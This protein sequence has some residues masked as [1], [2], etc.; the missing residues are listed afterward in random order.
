MNF[1]SLFGKHSADLKASRWDRGQF[2][3]QCLSCG[4]AMVKPP[5][6]EWQLRKA[7]GL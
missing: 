2:V 7:G 4:A 3:S 5:G 6:L 1:H